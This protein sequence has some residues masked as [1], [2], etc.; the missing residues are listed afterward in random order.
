MKSI[1]NQANTIQ[2]GSSRR[3][4]QRGR[5]LSAAIL[6]LVPLVSSQAHH[7]H[8]NLD[9]SK[10]L[11]HKGTVVKYGWTMPHVYMKVRAPNTKGEIVE[12]SIEML[13]PPAM[14]ERGWDRTTFKPGDMIT[15]EGPPDKNANRY[16]SGLIWAEKADGSRLTLELDETAVEPSTDFT[17][18]W[19]RHLD[20]PKRYR[21]PADWP[22]TELGARLVANFKDSDNPQ[23]NCIDPG[24]PKANLLP[25]PMKISRP[26]ADTLVID[27][28]GRDMPRIIHLDQHKSATE[29]SALGYSVGRFEGNE[30]VIE[31]TRFVD[32]KW[33][34]YTGVD[35]SRQKHLIERLSLTE[36]GL[37]MNFTMIVTDPVYL[38][39]PVT[40]E[41]KLRKLHDRELVQTSCTTESSKMF[42]ESK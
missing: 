15:W 42:L 38:T 32:D 37:A 11:L 9:Q 2:G 21:P 18:L 20:V 16:Y 35:S 34:I 3:W 40:I 6:S 33:G 41:H 25:Y 13:H 19:S 8:A 7:S 4:G 14:K 1:R 23:I 31:T 12:Y 24:P 27:Y 28:E 39:E 29:S 30:L 26:D 5:L 36:G 17:G 22:Y 10:K